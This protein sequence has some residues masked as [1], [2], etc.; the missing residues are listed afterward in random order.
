M[1]DDVRLIVNDVEYGG[2]TS[3]QITRGIEAIAGGFALTVS[4]RWAGQARPW[5]IRGEDRCVVKIGDDVLITGWVDRRGHRYDRDSHTLSVE[6][7]DAAG[8]LVDC[9]AVLASTQFSG[10]GIRELCAKVAKPFGIDVTVQDGLVDTAISTSPALASGG[11]G[12][13]RAVGS[14]GALSSMRIGKVKAP[15]TINPGESAFDV[16]DRACR[17][18]G[19]LPVSDGQG[20]IVLT[21]AGGLRCTTPLVEG[22]NILS[23]DA[24]Y[25]ESKRYARYLVSGQSA[26]DNE[27]NSLAASEIAAVATDEGVRRTERVLLI[28]P[29]VGSLSGGFAQVRAAWEATVRKARSSTIS[30]VVQGW[31]QSDGTLWPINALVDVTS[32]AIGVDGQ[33]L[34]TGVTFSLSDEAGSTTTLSLTGPDAFTPEPVQTEQSSPWPELRNGV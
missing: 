8:A 6:G 2:W 11:G 18:V 23:V 20:A 9:S 24:S 15:F 21:R 27:V 25:D 3:A 1:S 10:I 28:R 26:G 19:V 32:P 16:I 33:M 34:I 4:E 17:I 13:P 30:V 5:P 12:A 7:R 14:A 22:E 31:T 29:E